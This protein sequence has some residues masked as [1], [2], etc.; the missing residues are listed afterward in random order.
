MNRAEFRITKNKAEE[1]LILP[2]GISLP[3]VRGFLESISRSIYLLKAM[4]AFLAKTMHRTTS[5]SSRQLSGEWESWMPRKNP[6][7]AKGM[8]KIV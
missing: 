1:G 8:A 4:A 7:M 2:A 6:V 3:E 5:N